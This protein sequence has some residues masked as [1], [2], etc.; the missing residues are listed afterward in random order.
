MKPGEDSKCCSTSDG[1]KVADELN[2]V[3]FIETSAMKDREV[4]DHN[5]YNSTGPRVTFLYNAII[6]QS[7]K[8]HSILTFHRD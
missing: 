1:Q 8:I 7:K 3:A 2:C 4:L 6:K 5:R